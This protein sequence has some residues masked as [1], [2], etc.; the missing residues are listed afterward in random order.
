M[1]KSVRVSDDERY[2]RDRLT[3]R[4][5]VAAMDGPDAD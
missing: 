1:S 4:D 5:Q 2:F 3:P